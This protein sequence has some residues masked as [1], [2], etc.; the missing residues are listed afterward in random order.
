MNVREIIAKYLKDNGFDG[1]YSPGECGCKLD[2]LMPCDGIGISCNPEE[3]FPGFLGPCPAD[4]GEHDFHIG[5]PKE[6][7]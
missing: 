1:L 6:E 4:C 3:C 2:D 7:R 5:N